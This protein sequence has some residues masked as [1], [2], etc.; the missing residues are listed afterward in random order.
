MIFIAFFHHNYYWGP[1]K[2]HL[3]EVI[4]SHSFAQKFITPTGSSR[5]PTN[6]RNCRFTKDVTLWLCQ[7]FANMAIEFFDGTPIKNCDFSHSKML[8]YQRIISWNWR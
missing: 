8:A 4:L 2:S 7:Q 5:D 6:V 1:K 3:V